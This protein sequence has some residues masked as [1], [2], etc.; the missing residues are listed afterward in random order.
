MATYLSIK[1][2][3]VL[4]VDRDA[5][6]YPLTVAMSTG[7]APAPS[8]GL[9]LTPDPNGGFDASVAAAGT[10]TFTYRAQNSQGTLSAATATVTLIFP[11]ASNLSVRVLDGK[12][13]T[14]QITDYRW[15]I[16]EDRTF[17]VNPNCTTNPPAAGCP[18]ASS[19]I[20]PTFGTNFHTSYMPL[21]AD[22][23]T[24]PV[25]CEGG[26]TVVDPVTGNHVN[27]VCDVG[28]GVC[29]PDNTGTGQT[30]IDPGKVHLDPTN[31]LV[32]HEDH[33]V[34]AWGRDFAD[35]S[36]LHGVIL[37]GGS[38]SYGVAVEL[39]ALP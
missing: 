27:A 35:V 24:G 12:N 18:T 14:T 13:K 37:G 39:I 25:S 32:A 30:P 23:C 8:A 10:Y 9:T 16:E 22:G 15:I 3:G 19:G 33:V 28:N 4:S 20:V 2:P 1:S 36:P 29:R 5:A 7:N 11:T 34:L 17:Y 31:D 6:G 38:H 26:Q 21:V